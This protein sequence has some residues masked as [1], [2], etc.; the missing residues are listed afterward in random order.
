MFIIG[1]KVLVVVVSPIS[2]Y[3]AVPPITLGM[4]VNKLMR[5]VPS[6]TDLELKE[7]RLITVDI[8]N[9]KVIVTKNNIMI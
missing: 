6:L 5:K 8:K 4:S 9:A 7:I 2:I 1:I 3:I